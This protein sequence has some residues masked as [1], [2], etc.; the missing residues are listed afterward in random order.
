MSL[1]TSQS[2]TTGLGLGLDMALAPAVDEGSPQ[3]RK[4]TLAEVKAE[5]LAA[6]RRTEGETML[7]EAEKAVDVGRRATEGSLQVSVPS[8]AS[9]SLDRS[10]L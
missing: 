10:L 9:C 4:R 8:R 2:G 3:T 1:E 5:K 7:R 6:R